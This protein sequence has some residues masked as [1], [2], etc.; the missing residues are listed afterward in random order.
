MFRVTREKINLI[1]NV[2]NLNKLKYESIKICLTYMVI[3]L[4]WILFSDK[5]ANKFVNDKDLLVLV[6]T[7]KGWFYVIVTSFILYFLIGR[8]LKKVESAEEKLKLQLDEI[9]NGK[10]LLKLNEERYKTLV[11]NS[12][13]IIYS[14]DENGVFTAVNHK[15]SQVTGIP[16]NKIIGKEIA[17]IVNNGVFNRCWGDS[18]MQVINSGETLYLENIHYKDEIYYVT[19]SPIFDIKNR[20]IGVTGT[21]QNVTESKKNEQIIRQMAYYDSLTTLPNRVLFY[22]KVKNGIA[23]SKEKG[24]KLIILFLDMDNFKRVNDTFGHA[25]G[26]ELLKETAKRLQ[27]CMRVND[28]A[29]RISGDEF[30]ILLQD[31]EDVN[32]TLPLIDKILKSFYKHFYIGSSTINVTVSIGV[33]VFPTDAELIEDLIRCADT[34]MYRAKELGRNRY[35]FFNDTMKM[36]EI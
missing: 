14:C 10:E 22:D 9:I 24:T 18:I 5:I 26:D 15:F 12:Q 27:S 6:S 21:N 23:L 20:V 13:N 4:I 7:Y 32:G 2:N 17:E 33:S 3:G 25:L 30:A 11:N 19:L 28:I 36:K 1:L 35:Q 29:A 8:I 31:V 34:A 16:T